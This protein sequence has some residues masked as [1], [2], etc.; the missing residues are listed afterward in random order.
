[1]SGKRG[2]EKRCKINKRT[3]KTFHFLL[4]KRKWSKENRYWAESPWLFKD[5]EEILKHLDSAQREA[6]LSTARYVLVA[7]PPGSGKTRVLAARFARLV[8]EGVDPSNMVALTFTC[9]AA[10]EMSGRVK[11][12][13]GSDTRAA[14]MGTFH[15]LALRV[16]GGARPGLAIIG[17]TEEEAILR[18]LGVKRAA[19]TASMISFIKNSGKGEEDIDEELRKVLGKYREFLAVEGLLDLD[20]LVPEATALLEEGQA[21]SPLASGLSHILVDEYQDINAPQAMF[22]RALAGRGAALFA[23]GDPDQAIYSFRGSDLGFFMRFESDWP[24][25]VVLNLSNNYRSREKIVMAATSLIGHNR[26]RLVLSPLPLRSGGTLRLVDCTDEAAEAR[27]II[28]EIEKRMGG[29][30]SL[31]SD[32]AVEDARFSDF[33]VLFRSRRAARAL[34]EALGASSLPYHMAG[35]GQGIAGF[36]A[37]LREARPAPGLTLTALVEEEASAAGLGGDTRDLLLWLAGRYGEEEASLVLGDFINEAMVHGAVEETGIE[38][39][40]VN[41]LTLHGAKGL[42][43]RVVFIIGVE[44]G[45]IPLCRGDTPIEEERRLFYVGLTRAAEEAL[46]LRAGKRRLFGQVEETRPSPFIEELGGH[47]VRERGPARARR[48]PR[49]VVRGLFD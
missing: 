49:P 25:A 10:R 40:K 9:R 29:L 44:E 22:L 11:D 4:E 2:T 6:V 28:S 38:A 33:A 14:H 18:D 21:S 47:L 32:G 7:A 37:L 8:K 12:L 20:D 45:L 46:L 27:Y 48:R 17:R 43:F 19:K 13:L 24:G 31:T 30:T 16:L 15:A 36:L 42:E 3:K 1:M 23:I 26:E 34:V 35:S 41:L 39:D 5:M